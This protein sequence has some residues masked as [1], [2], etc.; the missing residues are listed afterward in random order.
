MTRHVCARCHPSHV[1]S[2]YSPLPHTRAQ[3]SASDIPTK[4]TPTQASQENASEASQLCTLVHRK[5]GPYRPFGA[6]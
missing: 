1:S 6:V 2:Q 5:A 3:P 4:A